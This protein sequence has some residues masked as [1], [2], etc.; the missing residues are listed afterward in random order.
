MYGW[1]NRSLYFEA[2]GY[3]SFGPT[4]LKLTGA[5]LGPG[6]T[7]NFAP[8]GRI[9]YE[10]NWAQQS[11]HIGGL[12]FYADLIPATG[13]GSVDGSFGRNQYVDY[14]IDAGYQFLGD[15]THV[16]TVDAIFLRENHMP[17]TWQ[18][19]AIMITFAGLSFAAVS[20]GH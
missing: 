17:S 2:G 19:I 12:I 10:W 4:A 16:A 7:S 15:G 11:A 5:S 6:A 9:A 18:M 14:G 1:Y 13:E 20:F 8:Y 3:S